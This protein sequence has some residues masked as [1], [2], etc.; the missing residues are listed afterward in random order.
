MDKRSLSMG[1][2]ISR[3]DFLL[4]VCAFGRSATLFY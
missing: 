2:I 3:S 1:L 4:T